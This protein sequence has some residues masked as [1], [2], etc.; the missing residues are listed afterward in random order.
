M[1]SRA[2]HSCCQNSCWRRA[3]PRPENRR[4]Q[5]KTLQPDICY[6]TS[7]WASL[8]GRVFGILKSGK[9]FVFINISGIKSVISFDVEQAEISWGMNLPS[10]HHP[11]QDLLPRGGSLEGSATGEQMKRTFTLKLITDF[12]L[13]KCKYTSEHKLKQSPSWS[14]TF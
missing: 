2:C 5:N 11:C 13:G 6:S 8:I 14:H 10:M 9:K 3:V 1:K 4:R 12:S 7:F